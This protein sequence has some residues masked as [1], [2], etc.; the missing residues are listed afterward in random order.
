MNCRGG[1]YLSGGNGWDTADY[2]T[3]TS[4]VRADMM[5]LV[6]GL[7]DGAGDSFNSI[8]VIQ[9]SDFNDR[10]YGDHDGNVIFG[11]LGND[12][13]FGRNGDDTLD[14]GDGNDILLGGNG[15]DTLEG[16]AGNDQLF[17]HSGDDTLNGGDGDDFLSGGIGADAFNGGDGIDSVIFSHGSNTGVTASLAHPAINEGDAFGDTYVSIE[18]LYGTAWDDTLFGDSGDNRL[19]GWRGD[20]NLFGADGNDWIVG[21]DGEDLINGGGGDDTLAGQTDADVFEFDMNHGA[22][23]ILGFGQGEDL[24][25]YTDASIDFASLTIAQSGAHVLITSSAGTILVVGASAG[26]FDETDFLFNTMVT[27]EVMDAGDAGG[28]I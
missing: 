17:G 24:I 11:G 28:L 23:R 9:G 26:D 19:I 20:D 3:A 8:E 5:G 6:A 16:G 15:V 25:S 1:D 18:N 22:D 10:F 2:S 7:G 4:A 13:L 14:G 12:A 21:G 27:Q